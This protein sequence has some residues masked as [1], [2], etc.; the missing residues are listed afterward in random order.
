[1]KVTDTKSAPG[2]VEYVQQT[3]QLNQPDKARKI[4]E[5]KP[6]Q[7]EDR[8]DLSQEAKEMKKIHD[9]LTNTPDIRSEKVEPLA[10]QVQENR[11]SVDSQAVADKMTRET[12]L[13]FNK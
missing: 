2:S 6:S 10:K 1:M 9:V 7:T 4:T 11:Y 12:L 3:Q 5:G 8:V 13:E